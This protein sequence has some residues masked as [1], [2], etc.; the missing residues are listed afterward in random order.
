[1]QIRKHSEVANDVQQAFSGGATSVKC[2]ENNVHLPLKSAL[3]VSE[4]EK[5][6]LGDLT[7]KILMCDFL[8]IF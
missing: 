8:A 1:M 2:Y 7:V 3:N 6:L 5:Q 4:N